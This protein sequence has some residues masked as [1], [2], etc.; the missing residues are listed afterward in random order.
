MS[1][2]RWAMGDERRAT[3]D[4]RW[5][6]GD[7]RCETTSGSDGFSRSFAQCASRKAHRESAQIAVLAILALVPHPTRRIPVHLDAL[8]AEIRPDGLGVA[9]R[10]L[11]DDDLLGGD[12]PLLH[13]GF[14]AHHGDADLA[15]VDANVA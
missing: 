12:E 14:L 8:A 15:V 6:M 4:G 9:H 10:G 5:A 2:E 3:G 11:A 7:G 13:H 1:D